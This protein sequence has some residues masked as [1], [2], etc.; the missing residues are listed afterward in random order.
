[1]NQPL[2]QD[3]LKSFKRHAE[4]HQPKLDDFSY[5]KVKSLHYYCLNWCNQT[6]SCTGTDALW[7]NHVFKTM[8][9]QALGSRLNLMCHLWE[10][11]PVWQQAYQDHQH[12]QNQPNWLKT[13]FC[14][15]DK[16]GFHLLEVEHEAPLTIQQINPLFDCISYFKYENIRLQKHN[17]ELQWPLTPEIQAPIKPKIAPDLFVDLDQIIEADPEPLN[18]Q[19][20]QALSLRLQWHSDDEVAQKMGLSLQETRQLYTS[21]ADKNHH[22]Y[23]PP[24]V[25][26]N[27]LK[28]L[29]SVPSF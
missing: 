5:L 15:E 22:P 19:E 7:L 28:K 1:M 21:I 23:I 25:Y 17:P 27:H 2:N 26:Q 16:H 20:E 29:I 4:I 11:N 10:D 9:Y 18:Q 14:L 3:L 6:L 8:L 24:S 13:D 12:Q